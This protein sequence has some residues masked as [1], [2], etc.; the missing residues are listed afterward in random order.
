M[1]K[2]KVISLKAYL[3]KLTDRLSG[4]IPPKHVNRPESYKRFLR[5]EIAT[6]KAKLEAAT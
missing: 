2:E 4:E 1:T 3:S 6:V 5:N